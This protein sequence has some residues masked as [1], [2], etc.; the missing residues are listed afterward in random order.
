M[1]LQSLLKSFP[2]IKMYYLLYIDRSIVYIPSS[3]AII[4]NPLIPRSSIGIIISNHPTVGSTITLIVSDPPILRSFILKVVL[5]HSTLGSLITFTPVIPDTILIT[6]Y[7]PCVHLSIYY[8]PIPGPRAFP[9][10]S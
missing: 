4:P 7:T 1:K 8:T 5:N 9:H 2:Q 3:S 6:V 10:T